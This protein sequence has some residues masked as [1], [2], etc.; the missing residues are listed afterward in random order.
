MFQFILADVQ[1]QLKEDLHGNY[2]TWLINEL[3]QCKK[4]YKENNLNKRERKEMEKNK[5]LVHALDAAI[6]II[7]SKQKPGMHEVDNI[8]DLF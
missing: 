2:K 8:K 4:Q 6:T 3:K 7:A 1:K 5:Y